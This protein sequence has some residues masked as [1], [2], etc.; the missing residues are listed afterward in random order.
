[1]VHR[2]GTGVHWRS[3]RARCSCVFCSGACLRRP[4]A[5][6]CIDPLPACLTGVAG[7]AGWLRWVGSE[8]WVCCWPDGADERSH[9]PAPARVHSFSIFPLD[10]IKSR[11]QADALNDQRRYRGMWD[12]AVQSYRAGGVASLYQGLGF[13]L[14]RAVPVASVILPTYDAVS[15]SSSSWR[16]RRMQHR[17]PIAS[18]LTPPS[19][20]VLSFSSCAA[21]LLHPR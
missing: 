7:I 11:M 9:V 8:R 2:S 5:D 6:V 10:V 12:C 21:G 16:R 4:D 15:S 3:R 19:L 13:T 14:V 1:M 18:R 20:S 17:R